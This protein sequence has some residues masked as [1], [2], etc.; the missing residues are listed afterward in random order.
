MLR[1]LPTSVYNVPAMETWLGEQARKGRLITGFWGDYG[2]LFDKGE[3]RAEVYRLEPGDGNLRPDPEKAELYGAAGWEFVV[4]TYDHTLWLFRACRPDPSPIHTDPETQAI[5]FGRLRRKL[6]LNTFLWAVLFALSVGIVLLNLMRISVWQVIREPTALLVFRPAAFQMSLLWGGL[7]LNDWL[8]LRRLLKPLR[9]GIPMEHSAPYRQGRRWWFWGVTALIPLQLLL[10]PCFSAL[11]PV[12]ERQAGNPAGCSWPIAYVQV[13]DLGASPERRAANYVT[14]TDSIL[15][16]SYT[17]G[18][19]GVTF[20]MGQDSR[21][22]G[23]TNFWR[24]KVPGL[25]EALTREILHDEF[26]GTTRSESFRAFLK[27]EYPDSVNPMAASA[28]PLADSRFDGVW[29]TAD[30][31]VQYLLLRQGRT[32]LWMRAE[33]V[34]ENLRD[35]LDDFAAALDGAA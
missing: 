28:E 13:E 31:D 3:P 34:P 2:A 1:V 14:R 33:D 22:Q 12:V 4:S 5:A 16:E 32:V 15:G 9:A 17:I 6:L 8:A 26:P 11:E 24:L 35:H 30:G 25:A 23:R 20:A 18:D 29:Y 7:A 21:L 10:I 19:G 27:E